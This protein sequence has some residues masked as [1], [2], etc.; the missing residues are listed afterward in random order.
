MVVAGDDGVNFEVLDTLGRQP[1]SY[2]RKLAVRRRFNE[3]DTID[4]GIVGLDIQG[5]DIGFPVLVADL[6][7]AF[8]EGRGADQ[9][10]IV[11]VHPPPQGLLA[12]LGEG[13]KTVLLRREFADRHDL[14]GI[15]GQSQRYQE[16]KQGQGGHPADRIAVQADRIG[17]AGRDQSQGQEDDNAEDV[18]APPRQPIVHDHS[19]CGQTGDVQAENADTGRRHASDR[20]DQN[21][22]SEYLGDGHQFQRHTDK[23]PGQGARD[24]DLDRRARRDGAP[25][26]KFRPGQI[27]QCQP[28]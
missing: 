12:L 16:K 17:I 21:E 13:G 19:R 26:G 28:G 27:S 6:L 23:A 1:G 18:S 15:K 9:G 10:I 7:F 2:S 20:T 5:R 4:A 14:P 22:K 8:P 3:A 24:Q 11:G 25:D